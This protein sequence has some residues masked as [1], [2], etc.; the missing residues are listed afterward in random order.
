MWSRVL[1]SPTEQAAFTSLLEEYFQRPPPIPAATVAV[2]PRRQLAPLGPPASSSTPTASAPP[3]V[4]AS[5]VPQESLSS[6]LQTA[7]AGAALRNT[8]VTSSALRQTGL[9]QNAANSLAG[10][11]AKHHERLAPHVAAAARTGIAM[12]QSNTN[13]TGPAKPTGLQSGKSMAGFTKALFSSKGALSKAEQDKNKYTGPLYVKPATAP[14]TISHAP[15]PKRGAAP[16]PPPPSASSANETVKALY[17]YE[18]TEPEDLPVVEGEQLVVIEKKSHDLL[19]PIPRPHVRFNLDSEPGQPASSPEPSSTSISPPP[20]SP[21]PVLPFG[22]TSKPYSDSDPTSGVPLY[23]YDEDV[24]DGV[25]QGS[26]STRIA[27]SSKF[28]L[29]NDD[30]GSYYPPKPLASNLSS[31]ETEFDQDPDDLEEDYDSAPLMEGLLDHPRAK[32]GSLDLR[33]EDRRLKALERDAENHEPPDWL[34]RGGGVW[35]GIA[36]MSNSILGAGIIGL[37]YALREAGLLSGIILLLVLG[38]VTDWTIRLIVLNAKMSGR[39]SYIDIM[40]SCF[41]K[42]GRAACSFFQFAFAFGGMCAFCVIL[43][44]TIPRVLQSVT[45]ENANGFIKFLVS[46]QVVTFLLTVGISYPLSLYRDIEKLSHASALALVSMVVIVISVAVRGPGVA[47][48]LKGDPNMRW[49]VLE[50]GFFEAIGVISFAFVCHHNSLLIYG[51]L[52]TPTLDRFAQVT[53]VST[54][55]SVVACLCMSTSGFLVFTDRTQGNILNNFAEDDWLINVARACFGCNMFATLPLEAFV[56]REVAETYFW[57]DE[58]EFNK[59]RHVLITSALVFSALIVSLITCD[60]GLILELAGGFSATAL[61]YLFPAACFL[62]LSGHGTQQAPQRLA[63]WV[64]AVF[65]IG[66]MVLSTVLSIR[67]ALKGGSHKVC[68]G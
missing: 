41:G 30:E 2:Q 1:E 48:S 66:V 7:A 61:A 32:R 31:R 53:H 60:L 27:S 34:T 46:R 57:P 62:K 22:T 12:Q 11:G 58:K 42:K 29:D 39:R 67:K 43:G 59:R 33:G 19:A 49:T 50:A 47:D 10:F 40:D 26:S 65:G 3:P 16:P 13:A 28:R 55:L 25:V 51:S 14:G 45:G 5:V 68:V 38:V 54:I 56:C 18:G 21:Q 36:N 37:P 20:T 64:C 63:A 4:S 23:Q 35:A 6:R 24:D 8:T 17:D 44:D 9:S 15:P 52:R